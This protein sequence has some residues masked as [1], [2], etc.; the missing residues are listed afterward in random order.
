MPLSL[1]LPAKQN[2]INS[3]SVEICLWQVEF[4]NIMTPSVVTLTLVF[5]VYLF[6]HYSLLNTVFKK[7]PQVVLSNLTRMPT[8][9]AGNLELVAVLHT[10]QLLFWRS[11]LC[12]APF[13]VM[14][15]HQGEHKK[16]QVV[17]LCWGTSSITPCGPLN[18][19]EAV[20]KLCPT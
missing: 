8:E 20:T 5:S 17:S 18:C 16:T 14:C 1:I 9:H 11:S 4:K 7:H 2:K 15:V 10:V 19:C 6:Q 12:L 3:I 13:V